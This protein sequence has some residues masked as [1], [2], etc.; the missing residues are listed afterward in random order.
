MEVTAFSGYL[1]LYKIKEVGTTP[2]LTKNTNLNQT[3][4]KKT[5][6]LMFDYA[7]KIQRFC[8]K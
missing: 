6:H 5:N 3:C 1:F 4:Y 8:V 2:P 7:A